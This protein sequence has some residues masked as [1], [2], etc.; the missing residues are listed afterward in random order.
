MGNSPIH[1][2][3]QLLDGTRE[4]RPGVW[5]ARCPEHD[6]KSP[7]L[8]VK[9]TADD[10]V[11]IKCWAGCGAGEVVASVGLELRDLFPRNDRFDHRQIPAR[12]KRPWI[13][14]D[15]LRALMMEAT[16]VAVNAGKLNNAG[17]TQ[18]DADRLSL[19]TG[20][21]AAGLQAPDASEGRTQPHRNA[22]R[23]KA[24]GGNHG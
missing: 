20:Q 7:S 22:G 8:S 14:M 18:E 13:A 24:G 1:T 16:V 9:E 3:L 12:E 21:K 17:L 23:V 15:V 2:L 10:T 6:D 19:A 11:L 5:Q 4:T